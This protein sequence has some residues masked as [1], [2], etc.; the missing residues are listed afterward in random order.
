VALGR[1]TARGAIFT[2]GSGIFARAIGLASTLLLAR[3]LSPSTYGEV[4]VA[5]VLVMTATQLSTLGLGQY[6]IA[7]PEAP[8]STAFHVT[9]FHLVSGVLALAAVLVA[10]DA[11]GVAFDAPHVALYLPG[12]ALSALLDR[13]SYV[14]ERVLVRE[15]RFGWL[16][17]GRTAADLAYSVGSIVLAALGFGASAI[18]LGNLFRSLVRAAAFIGG[19]KRGAWLEPSRLSWRETRELF[20]FGAPMALGASAAFASRRWD[21]LLVAHFF[22]PGPAGAY[23]LAYNLADVPAIQI[24]EQI[25]DVLLPSFA[26]LEPERRASALVRSMALLALVVFPLA[27]GLG[28]VAPTLVAL[29]FDERWQSIGPMLVLLSALSVA[30]PVGW[31]VASYLQASGRPGRIFWLELLKLVALV[32]LILT[33]GRTSPLWTCGAVGV[34]FAIHALASLWV[35]ERSDGVPLRRLL[36]SLVPALV[37]CVPLVAAVLAMRSGNRA[38]GGLGPL[39]ELLLEILAGALGYGL[40]AL[41]FARESSAELFTRLVDALRSRREPA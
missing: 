8:A 25:G 20:R 22:G 23:N 19:V 26:R 41:L 37:A 36:G 5:A 40:G 13:V 24:G 28:A 27:V 4:T 33:L 30:R 9:V 32:G 34:A 39:A 12:L 31:T 18:V 7:H 38:L 35:I 2:I 1:D 17:A 14:P 15:L 11:L 16:S 21:N 29:L 3:F 6:L 10:G